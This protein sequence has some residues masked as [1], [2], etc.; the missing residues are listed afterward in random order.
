MAKTTGFARN[1]LRSWLDAT[2][3][4]CLSPQPSSVI[5]DRLDGMI[6]SQIASQKNRRMAT[7]IL[8]TI[9]S[10]PKAQMTPFH[11]EARALYEHAMTSADRLAL[12]Y[13]LT[14]LVYPFFRANVVLIGQMSHVTTQLT[15]RQLKQR[16]FASYGQLG[17]VD[18]A[19]ERV[20]FSLRDWHL[21]QP[22]KKRYTYEICRDTL[23]ITD[24][25]IEEWLLAVL[26]FAHSADELLISELLHLPEAFPFQISRTIDNLRHSKRF[27]IHRQGTR[28]DMVSLHPQH[29]LHSEKVPL[30]IM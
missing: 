25:A 8:V 10:P 16:V 11:A 28:D 3:E 27:E 21:L 23:T 12:H 30:L 13:G 2:A 6:V 26:L 24:P 4:L 20:I 15:A 29:R 17:A 19:V 18:K 22:G 1:I 5:R 7:N 14:T 9:W